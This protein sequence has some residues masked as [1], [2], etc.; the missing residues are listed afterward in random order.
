MITRPRILIVEDETIVAMDIAMTLRRLGY[1]VAGMVVSGEA[2]IESART[3]NPDLILMD[4]RIRG[5]MDGVEAATAIQRDRPT[6]VVFLTAHADADT[7]ERSKSAAPFGYLVKPF[8][9]R[10]L[11]R[12]VEI[13][14]HRAQMEKGAREETLDALWQSEESFRLLV[15]AVKDYALFIIDLQYRIVSWNPGAERM[16]GFS[17]AEVIGKPFSILRSGGSGEDLDLL[18]EQIRRDGGA[19]W[20]DAGI[21][22]DGSRYMPYVYCAP[23][24]D[25]KGDVVGYVSITRDVTEQ[26]MLQAQLA[27]TQRLESLGQL[28]GGVAHD[29]N[30]MLMVIFSRCEILLRSIEDKELRRFISDIRMAANKN[31]ELTQQLLAAARRQMLEPEVVNVNEVVI[32]AMRLL[33]PTIG[34]QIVIRTELQ[35]PLWNVCADPGKLHQVLI[36]LAIN[37]RDAMPS[38]G[39]LTIETRNVHLDAS[40]TRQH[41][42]VKEG[43]YVTLLISDTGMGI[44]AEIRDRIYDPFFTTKDPAR[45][46]GLGLA[47]VRGIVE[48]TGGRIWVYSEENRGTTFRILLPRHSGNPSPEVV[49][50]QL[51]ERGSETILLVEDEELLRTVVREALEEH[52]YDVLEARSPAE[53]LATSGSTAKPI[54]LLLSDMIMPGMTGLD[55]AEKLLV[56]RPATRLVFMSGYSNHAVPSPSALP[57][58]AHYLEKPVPTPLLLRTVRSALDET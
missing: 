14:L 37:A 51:P 36:N 21:R 30:N 55:L 48:Q 9:E 16:T 49:D 43:D 13:A 29:F 52:G 26:R 5:A 33:T 54:H 58:G 50:E 28:A 18:F 46:T 23:M 1:D 8:D 7:V 47:V 34:E 24:V 25:R 41:I 4:I 27:Q 40:Y 15:D 39:V 3:L 57:T 44:A 32:S 6:P 38:G 56:E 20:E 12:V 19:E 35:D 53:A 2:A 17:A 45:G 11:H 42:G 10:A 22:K 31:R